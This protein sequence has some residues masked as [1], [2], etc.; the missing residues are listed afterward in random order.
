MPLFQIC[1]PE[2]KLRLT[3]NASL[4]L[5]ERARIVLKSIAHSLNYNTIYTYPPEIST[6]NEIY[7]VC[8]T[9]L[10]WCQFPWF[11]SDNHSKHRC[12][13]LRWNHT[14]QPLQRIVMHAVSVGVAYRQIS[15]PHRSV[16]V[17][18]LFL[19]HRLHV[20]ISCWTYI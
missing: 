7:Y 16:I 4:L 12:V 8:Y 5:T 2:L 9:G 15:Y 3:V 18:K 17:F 14:K 13:G 1:H 20:V 11:E 10:E 6:L 19:F